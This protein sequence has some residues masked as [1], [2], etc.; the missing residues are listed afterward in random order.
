M[1][2]MPIVVVAGV[3]PLADALRETGQFPKVIAANTTKELLAAITGPDVSRHSVDELLFIFGD[4]VVSDDST[5][6]LSEILRR[7]TGAGYQAIVVTVTPRGAELQRANPQAGL[8]A[9]PLYVNDVLYAIGT[10]GYPVNP[11]SDEQGPLDLSSLTGA[12]ATSQEPPSLGSFAWNAPTSQPAEEVV[13]SPGSGWATPAPEVEKPVVASGGWSVPDVEPLVPL[14]ADPYNAQPAPVTPPAA[15]AWQT[16]APEPAAVPFATVTSPAPAAPPAHDVAREPGAWSP[17]VTP[18]TASTWTTPR[19]TLGTSMAPET[20]AGTWSPA[21]LAGTAGSVASRGDAYTAV[22]TST[23]RRGMVI[24]IAVSKGGVGKSS[25]TLN[26][27]AFLGMRLRS[28]G[29]TVAVIDANYQQADSGKY[30]DTYTPN[31]NTILNNPSLLSAQRITEALVHKPEYNLSVLL[32]PATPD[33]GNPLAL[34]PRIYN[35]ILD[36]LKQHYDYI[37]IDTPVAEKYHEM[38]NK[39][40][41]VRADY[42]VVPVAPNFQTLHNADNW[43]RAAVVAPHHAQGAGMDP[44]RVGIVLNRAEE[45][46]GCSEDDVRQTMASWHFLGSIPETK[47]WKAANNRNE[48]VA[49]KNYAE[50]SQ[51]FAEVLHAATGEPVLLENLGL[52]QDKGSGVLG[53]LKGVFRRNK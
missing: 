39:F 31:I 12:P 15:A 13:T 10:F 48:L 6:T 8:L 28:Q 33:E 23:R 36:L 50:L 34:G 32:G 43:L 49:P 40:A 29:K 38:F 5:M 11:V 41:L 16:P 14:T 30:L 42:I 46:I 52:V 22:P 45:G 3:Q 4:T 47:E 18:P 26:L 21:P 17:P 24:T 53:A 51:A 25:M 35:E 19:P 27:A 7:L 2:S 37:F 1:S 9:L 44:N 20:P